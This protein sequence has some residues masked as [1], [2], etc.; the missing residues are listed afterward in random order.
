[1]FSFAG[2]WPCLQASSVAYGEGSSAFDDDEGSHVPIRPL[3]STPIGTDTFQEVSTSLQR[4]HQPRG[5][6]QTPHNNVGRSLL[7]IDHVQ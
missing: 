2:A 1:M 3:G 4:Q 5:H 6:Y 7:A